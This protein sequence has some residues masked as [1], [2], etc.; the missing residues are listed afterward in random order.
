MSSLYS[1]QGAEPVGV[2]HAVWTGL[3]PAALV[4]LTL[5]IGAAVTTLARVIALPYGFLTWRWVTVV[6]WGLSLLIAAI[7]YIVSV[8]R[9]L[10]NAAAWRRLGLTTPTAIAYAALVVSALLMLLPVILGI[11]LPQHPAP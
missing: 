4:A 11:T 6:V 5:A 3:A 9:A 2:G 10:R 7:V 1:E 8:R